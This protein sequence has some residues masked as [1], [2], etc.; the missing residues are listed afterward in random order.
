MVKGC[1]DSLTTG[2]WLP[3]EEFRISSWV[4]PVGRPNDL[5]GERVCSTNR[6]EVNPLRT[7]RDCYC[8]QAK[9]LLFLTFTPLP[10]FKHKKTDKLKI[11]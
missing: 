11:Q 7:K 3:E 4:S 10:T 2:D 6:S 9:L 5:I 1:G 8:I